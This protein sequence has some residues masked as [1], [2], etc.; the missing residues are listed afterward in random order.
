MVMLSDE[1]YIM[2]TVL[3]YIILLFFIF[4]IMKI[5]DKEAH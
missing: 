5:T 4:L 3:F 1:K 2:V